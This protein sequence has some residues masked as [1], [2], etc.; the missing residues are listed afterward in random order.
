[1]TGATGTTYPSGA[2]EF[3]S[4]ICGVHVSWSSVFYVVFCRL[5][6][7][8]LSSFFWPLY[9]LSFFDLLLLITPFLIQIATDTGIYQLHTHIIEIQMK[10]MPKKWIL[11]CITK[12]KKM[13]CKTQYNLFPEVKINRNR[14]IQSTLN[15]KVIWVFH[16]I[17][18][19]YP[20]YM[21]FIDYIAWT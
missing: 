13:Q 1:M 16:G 18:K 5:L 2:P 4:G 15:C 3:T 19:L 6:F 10:I 8:L 21:Y 20:Y 11:R 12:V 17:N 7:V 9:C 14:L